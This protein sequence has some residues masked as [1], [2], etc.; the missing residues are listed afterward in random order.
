V[1]KLHKRIMLS[2]VYQQAAM[3]NAEARE[4]DP[5]NQLL[6][7]MPRRRLEMEAMRD[8]ILA[9]SGELD[10]STI[11]GRPFDFLPTPVVPR[12]SIYG[13]VNR[14]IISSLASTFDGANA[15]SC[16]A[17]RSETTVP[18]QTL[19]ALNSV[20]IQDR[21]AAFSQRSA[22]LEDAEQRIRF[23][24]R[25]AYSRDPQ[26]EELATVR[27]FVSNQSG[28][29]AGDRWQ[30]LAHVLLAANESVFVD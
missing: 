2:D 9:V 22:H 7:R 17:R 6:W 12:R 24:Y 29:A 28:E 15:A 18:Q 4:K 25:Q 16:T 1:K 27:Q 8:S 5:D 13:F 3:E 19:F 11:G 10:V 21:A 23:L 26:D 20:F 30:Q 14:D